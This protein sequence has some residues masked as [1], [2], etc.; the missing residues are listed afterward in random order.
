MAEFYETEPFTPPDPSSESVE[1]VPL[2]SAGPL[3][4]YW[5]GDTYNVSVFPE[6]VEPTVASAALL[7]PT[8]FAF[9]VLARDAFGFWR[10]MEAGHTSVQES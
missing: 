8:A 4:E 1:F 2:D 10:I 5:I 7:E 3:Y 6:G 9:R